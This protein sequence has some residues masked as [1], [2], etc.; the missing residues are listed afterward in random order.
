M[1]RN[2]PYNRWYH[3][4]DTRPYHRRVIK[5]A[6]PPQ[7]DPEDLYISVFTERRVYDEDGH[8]SYVPNERNLS[9]SGVNLLDAY[10]RFMSEGNSSP[11]L[12]CARHGI[13]VSDLHTL[14]LLLTGVDGVTFRL[15][16]QS[17]IIGELL[18]H[19][20]L[21]MDEVAKRSGLGTAMNLF[22]ACRREFD[23]APRRYREVIRGEGDLG[24]YRL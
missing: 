18:C 11:G 1:K 15:W 12:F 5:M 17:Q 16:W 8:I 20:N 13:E 19:T 23:C 3:F 7:F 9:P 2:K 24:R 6:E 22:Y 21:S 4:D 10:L 14:I